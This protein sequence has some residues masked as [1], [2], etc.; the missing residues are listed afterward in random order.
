MLP[1]RLCVLKQRW[2][3][4]G[5]ITV[6]DKCHVE[7]SLC[8]RDEVLLRQQLLKCPRHQ[9]AVNNVH[10]VAI[11]LPEAFSKCLSNGHKA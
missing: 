7:I 11:V 8:T 10:M 4:D 1:S 6:H 5:L 9:S 2:H 3:P